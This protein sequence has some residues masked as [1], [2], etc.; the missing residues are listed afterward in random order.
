MYKKHNLRVITLGLAIIGSLCAQGPVGNTV[1][2]TLDQNALV[3]STTKTPGDYTI[4]QVTSASNP[5]VLEFTTNRG[6]KLGPTVTAIPFLQNAPPW[7]TKG[8]FDN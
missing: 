1:Y 8:L 3:G 2:I 7:S 5:R 6:T 4:R